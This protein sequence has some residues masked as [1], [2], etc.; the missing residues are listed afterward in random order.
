LWN[1]LVHD[2]SGHY[3][4]GLTMAVAVENGDPVR[5]V[6]ELLKA[7][8]WPPLHGLLVVPTQ[9]LTGN[10]W[11][12]AVLPSLAGWVLMVV[13]V[14]I[15]A[16]QVSGGRDDA[17]LAGVVAFVFAALSPAHR[18]FATD[19]M[20]ESL[21]AGLTALAVV[22]YTGAVERRDDVRWWRACALVLT[23]LFFEK[24]NYWMIAVLALF[25]AEG[26]RRRSALP[27][28]GKLA[29]MAKKTCRRLMA[30][31][32]QPLSLLSLFLLAAV[33]VIQVHGPVAL[34]I[35]G[36]EI[37]LYPPRNLLTA[38]YAAAFARVFFALRKSRW[39]PNDP[40]ARVFC[41]WHVLPLAVSFLFPQRLAAFLQF[42]SPGNHGD[43]PVR[44]VPGAAASYLAAMAGDYHSSGTLLAAA[45]LLA[46]AACLSLGRGNSRL[47]APL[48][49]LFIG[50]VLTLLHPNQKSR[51]LHSWL[52]MLWVLAGAGAATLTAGLKRP[53][54]ARTLSVV[55]VVLLAL[56]GGSGWLDRGRSP[57]TGNRG[58]THSLLDLS[59][60]WLQ[61]LPERGGV[62][63]LSTQSCRPLVRW[64]FL[65]KFAD[66]RRIRWAEFSATTE[67][68]M[69]KEIRARLEESSAETLVTLEFPQD[70][71]LF[72]GVSDHA[73]LRAVLPTLLEEQNR[74]APV[75]QHHVMGANV[76]V[77]RRNSIP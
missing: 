20:L 35:F 17:W 41:S 9:I 3:G 27:S 19:I 8:V 34:K 5:F 50:L 7:K 39:R 53:A 4:Y 68:E 59:D 46:L 32:K 45:V 74:F 58:E 44:D 69:A 10:D 22:V 71:E 47:I 77:W 76:R 15:L 36:E 43:S 30:E 21:G 2:R 61:H 6:D 67:A 60:S 33:V 13:A 49:L 63:F 37:A 56:A 24:Y 55:L 52:P 48:A 18:I 73:M 16:M 28:A 65:E 42:L 23:L 12:F 72:F 40:V 57:E 29:E 11:R 62:L 1:G 26:W 14:S 25:C 38:A 51:Y 54:L 31:W 75:H 64:T 66:L 70:S